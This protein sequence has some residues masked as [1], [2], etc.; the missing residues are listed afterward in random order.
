MNSLANYSVIELLPNSERR[1]VVNVGIL[2]RHAGKWDIRVASDASKVQALNPMFPDGGLV[3]IAVTLQSLL[4]ATQ[5][6]QEARQY[7]S[8]AGSNPRLQEFVG[9]FP[10]N[11]PTE[12][13]KEINWL[14][15]ELITPPTL[16]A[17]A[18]VKVAPEHRLRTKLRTHFKRK[19]L[20]G[21]QDEIN[22][23]KIVEKYP[24]EATKGLYAEFALKNGGMHITETVDFDVSE[25]SERTKRLEAQAKTLILS[26]AKTLLG[27]KTKTYVVI[28]GSNRRVAKPS[29]SLL[30]D[31]AEVFAL[32]SATDMDSYFK[33]IYA[34]AK[35]SQTILAS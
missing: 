20:L 28:S 30:E 14:L 21:K 23:H 1:E 25:S 6:L 13:E 11:D 29:I 17:S 15:S 27:D 35:S 5:S 10:A 4:R 8:R 22:A 2:V 9:Q 24:I 7:L 34:A 33:K 16:P 32:E 3:S 26:A 18:I 31:Y 12:Y 19:H